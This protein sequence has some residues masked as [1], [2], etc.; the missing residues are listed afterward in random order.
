[1]AAC[2]PENYGDH[3]R[4]CPRNCQHGTTV[5]PTLAPAC[6]RNACRISAAHGCPVDTQLPA[7]DSPNSLQPSTLD[8]WLAQLQEHGWPRE[9][10]RAAGV[11]AISRA[12]L[13]GAAAQGSAGQPSYLATAEALGSAELVAAVRAAFP[14][15]G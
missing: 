9:Q 6:C 3:E 10:G 15:L 5:R 4:A 8:T 13:E 11:L 7:R 2:A 1:M 12:L 14:G